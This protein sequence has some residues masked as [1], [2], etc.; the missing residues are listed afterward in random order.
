MVISSVIAA[1]SKSNM[2]LYHRSLPSL[3]MERANRFIKL[4]RINA[5]LEARILLGTP[6]F[7]VII[8][9][10]ISLFEAG[11]WLTKNYTKLSNPSITG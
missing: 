9:I 7:L 3:R 6:R 10:A 1:P 11:G 8:F 2:T 4:P 5:D